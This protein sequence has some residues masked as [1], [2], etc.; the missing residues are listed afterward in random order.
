MAPAFILK[1]PVRYG[2]VRKTFDAG[3]ERLKC[4]VHLPKERRLLVGRFPEVRAK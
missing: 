2:I 4:N 3:R 1:P